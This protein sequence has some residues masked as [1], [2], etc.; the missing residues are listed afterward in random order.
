MNINSNGYWENSYVTS[1]HYNDST[2]AEGLI[3]F[4]RSESVSSLADFGCGNG[5][6]VKRLLDHDIS[7]IGFDGNPNTPI[8]TNNTCKVLDLSI[9]YKFQ[10]AFDW[11]ISLE[12]GE[13]LP[14][15][16]EDIFLDN[17]HNNNRNGI[18]LSWAIKGQ[19]GIGH[20]NEQNNDYIKKKVCDI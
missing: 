20:V 14:K 4:F 18:I 9:P 2:L 13:H 6:Y 3:S 16:F 8:M 12:V 7:S 19:G 1:G 11:V 17:L 10:E 5:Y 15:Q